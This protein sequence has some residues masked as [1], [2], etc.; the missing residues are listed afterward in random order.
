[1]TLPTIFCPNCGTL[2]LDASFCHKCNWSRPQPNV[3]GEIDWAAALETPLARNRSGGGTRPLEHNGVIFVPSEKGHIFAISPSANN[4]ILWRHRL[5]KDYRCDSLA[6][7]NDTIICGGEY[8]GTLMEATQGNLVGINAQSGTEQWRIPLD[9]SSVSTPVI[10]GN[11]AYLTVNTNTLYAIDLIN[12]DILWDRPLQSGWLWSPNAPAIEATSNTIIVPGRSNSVLAY[13]T[14]NGKRLWQFSGNG[15]FPHSPVVVDGVAYLRGWDK[16]IY[17]LDATTGKKLWQYPAPRD[18]SSD[19][20]VDANFLYVGVK[21]KE[22]KTYALHA[23]DRYTGKFAWKYQVA[24]HI[25]SR[26]T[27]VDS[28]VFFATDERTYDAPNGGTIIALDTLQQN[29]LWT[30]GVPERFQSDLVISQNN[31]IAGTRQGVVYAVSYRS[32][33]TVIESPQVYLE[34]NAFEDAAIAFAL[35]KD[36][37]SAAN[38]YERQL[39]SPLQ[40]SQLYL[41]GDQPK[42]VIDLWKNSTKPIEKD[43]VIQAIEKLPSQKEQAEAFAEI[44]DYRRAAE[45]Y[46]QINQPELAGRQYETAK[47][48]EKAIETYK[49]AGLTAK[50]QALY[51]QLEYWEELIADFARTENYFGIAEIY[52]QQGN[53]LQAGKHYDEAGEPTLALEAFA[54]ISN[55]ELLTAENHRF[56]GD[57]ARSK[58]RWDLAF[59][60][61][62]YCGDYSAAAEIAKS[63]F[64]DDDTALELYRLANDSKNVALILEEKGNFIEAAETWSMAGE[65]MQAG[66]CLLKQ[67]HRK[68]DQYGG[69][70][71]LQKDSELIEWLNRA[72]D[73]LVAER[74]FSKDDQEAYSNIQSKIDECTVTLTKV[75]AKPI[76]RVLIE[77]KPLVL[78]QGNL[79]TFTIGNEG[80]GSTEKLIARIFSTHIE[81]IE[82]KHIGTLKPTEKITFPTTIVP[83][84]AGDIH[85]VVNL[86]GEDGKIYSTTSFPLTVQKA[87]DIQAIAEGYKGDLTINIGKYSIGG[88]EI[89][90]AAIVNRGNLG[91]GST[92]SGNIYDTGITPKADVERYLKSKKEEEEQVCPT[93]H[94]SIAALLKTNPDAQRCIYC[95]APLYAP[96]EGEE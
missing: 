31:L 55:P 57:L 63:Q 95:G 47:D 39:S 19:I 68:I 32:D 16:N 43:L 49:S 89:N 36:Y 6:L 76:H 96:K 30:V 11:I 24:G 28:V 74:T 91:T 35:Q 54:K 64:N 93:C 48:F 17:A 53:Y 27:S 87:H 41:L 84:I 81:P 18:F 61:F 60:H 9:G 92:D 80:W 44:G 88:M 45:I 7:W 70:K 20:W 25:Y 90:D 1:M 82:P 37:I 71:K 59:K 75:E 29:L 13:H 33:E 26:P 21:E 62:R 12:Q 69:I 65:P 78:N 94:R 67:I 40:A 52:L 51:T 2:I 83:K 58:N 5:D 77:G 3:A 86:I 34:Q 56:I 23:I 8:G 10:H 72:I 46:V 50:L 79:I 42:S 38:I 85:I 22:P 4:H 15:W 73:I 66:E 14:R